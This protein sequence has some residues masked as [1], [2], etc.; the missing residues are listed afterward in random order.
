MWASPA[1]F[2]AKAQLQRAANV[3]PGGPSLLFAS[4]QLH[5]ARPWGGTKLEETGGLSLC[6]EA[7][8]WMSTS[9]TGSAWRL[10]GAKLALLYGKRERKPCPFPPWPGCFSLDRSSPKRPTLCVRL[11]TPSTWTRRLTGTSSRQQGSGAEHPAPFALAGGAAMQPLGWGV[12]EGLQGP[13]GARHP[14]GEKGAAPEPLLLGPEWA[15][16]RPRICPSVRP[17]RPGPA[18]PRPALG[19]R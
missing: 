15:M 7:Q 8:Q 14:R 16:P 17:S 6:L 18:P 1:V 11:L 10:G 3:E 2:L 13:R 12:G 4:C 9:H 5:Q 19:I